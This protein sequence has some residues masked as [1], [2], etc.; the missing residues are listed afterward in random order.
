MIKMQLPVLMVLSM[1]VIAF[2]N[3][4]IVGFMHSSSNSP[5]LQSEHL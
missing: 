1:P 2:F 3:I 4:K 5:F